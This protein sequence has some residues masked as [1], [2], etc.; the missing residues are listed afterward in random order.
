VISGDAQA[1]A[2]FARY[3]FISHASGGTV[4]AIILTLGN[5]DF[6]N[7]VQE[8]VSRKFRGNSDLDLESFHAQLP[9]SLSVSKID[10][11]TDELQGAKNEVTEFPLTPDG[12]HDSGYRE[13]I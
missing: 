11:P 3:A 2:I 4:D 5:V 13:W 9:V 1:N 10:P 8:T 6:V 12:E 7:W